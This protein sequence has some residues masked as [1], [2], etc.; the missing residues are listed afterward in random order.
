MSIGEKL[1]SIW[2]NYYEYDA[3]G[4][5]L[6]YKMLRLFQSGNKLKR[7]R[8]WFLCNKL[9]EKYSC[10]IYPSTQIKP[11]TTF[12]HLTNI[13]IG[14]TA[15][16]GERCQI[17]PN[18][19]VVAKVKG[20]VKGEKKRRHAL[21]GDDCILGDGCTII[22][23]VTIGDDCIIEGKAIVTHDVPAHSVVFGTN[24]VRPRKPEDTYG[25]YL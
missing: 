23:D 3:A 20:D 4:V 12:V 6:T 22:G 18:V 1:W 10:N 13:T 24:E 9:R 2:S 11:S 21:V 15:I 5:R 17:W 8:A 7:W 25:I 14:K 16:I 19:A